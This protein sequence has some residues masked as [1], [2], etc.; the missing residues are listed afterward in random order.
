MS[1]TTSRAIL[2]DQLAIDHRLVAVLA[3]QRRLAAAF[4]GDDDLVG[5]GE[6][7]AAEPRVDLAV[8][9][10]AELDVVF[11]KSIE[12][13]VGDLIADLVRMTFGNR[14]AGERK[15]R[16][17]HRCNSS[18]GAAASPRRVVPEWFLQRR[19]SEVKMRAAV[20]SCLD[21][22]GY[23]PSQSMPAICSTRSTMRR[24][25]LLLLMRINALV[26]DRPSEVARKSAT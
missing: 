4:A 14:L 18:R 21:T 10:D 26:S 12:D 5:G 23:D 2:R 22:M 13:R 17:S 20:G 15:L 24:R 19:R 9:G 7:L 1:L 25:S 3:E 6:R 8:V 16:V 11:Q